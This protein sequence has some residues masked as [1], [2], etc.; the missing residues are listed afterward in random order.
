[1][2][3]QFNDITEI[4]DSFELHTNIPIVGVRAIS[5]YTDNVLGTTVDRYF[6]KEFRYS[7]NGIT[8][9]DWQELTNDNLISSF[10]AGISI[11][12]IQYRYTRAGADSFGYLTFI[13]VS[14]QGTYEEVSTSKVFT[15]LYFNKFFDYNDASVLGWALNVLDK[16]YNRGIVANYMDR[17]LPE[18]ND[19]DYL[20]LFGAL[21]HFM[22]VIV[23]YA[24]EFR[25]FNNSEILLNN[26]LRQRGVFVNDGML[27]TDLQ[28][29]LGKLYINYLERGTNEIY[30]EIGVGSR[31]VDGELLRLLRKGELDEFVFGLVEIEK[32]IWNVNNNSPLYRGTKQSVNLIKAYEFT[33][34]ITNI[35]NYPLVEDS[36]ITKYTDGDKEVIRILNSTSNN[37]S[38]IG[39]ALTANKLILIDSRLSYEVTFWVKQAILSNSISLEVYL[40]DKD[41][42]LLTDSPI[43]A[44]SGA[45]TNV[46]F[47]QQQLL[48]NDEWYFIR[49]ILFNEKISI[50]AS[51]ILDIGFGNHFIINNSDA[52]Y[53]SIELGTE[54]ND[55]N[56]DLRI[57]DFKVR[58]LMTTFANGFIMIPNIITSF[59]DNKS[60]ETNRI[61]QNKIKRYLIPY[62]SILNNQFIDELYVP[63]GTPLKVKI[64]TTDETILYIANGSITL[65][66]TGGTPPYRYSIDNG[67]TFQDEA[68]FPNLAAGIYNIVVEDAE[69]VQVTDTATIEPG[70]DSLAFNTFVTL[71]ETPITSD[72][73]IEVIAYGGVAPYLYSLDNY[74]YQVSNVF[75]GLSA[76]TYTVY[77]CDSVANIKQKDVIV[78]INR[79]YLATYTIYDQTGVVIDYTETQLLAEFYNGEYAKLGG[80]RRTENYSSNNGILEIYLKDFGSAAYLTFT[81]SPYNGINYS[82]DYASNPANIILSP[83]RDKVLEFSSFMV[84][85]E[86]T[87]TATQLPIDSAFIQ[88][89]KDVSGELFGS[90]YSDSNGISYI[91]LGEQFYG[92]NFLIKTIKSGYYNYEFYHY[93]SRTVNEVDI[94]LT[95]V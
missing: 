22:A 45:Q 10:V 20:A 56:N 50:D 51:N 83:N 41:E 63:S 53:M 49:L 9:T 23:R 71:E 94:V 31:V 85:I 33:Q 40:Y 47:T 39:G 60:E 11:F 12:D 6:Y 73:Q 69:G 4:G 86:V 84:K 66:A 70:V 37:I 82:P 80:I 18:V 65:I 16:L 29:L 88:V 62:N 43:S 74:N 36:F 64:L 72:A 13:S 3:I 58:P 21:T 38:G 2:A 8:Y 32:T 79:P 54:I 52:K 48:Q 61:I 5:S 77:V 76:A 44:I 14:L 1:M 93:I 57:W 75:T 34:D 42:V 55:G 7:L 90:G 25:D 24:R 17:N 92:Q 30:K 15:D 27:L 26:Y 68:Y 67:V 87:D 28:A 78:G 95:S 89:F 19:D 91:Y 35:S 59:I 81:A 46:S